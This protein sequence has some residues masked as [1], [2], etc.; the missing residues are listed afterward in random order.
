[1]SRPLVSLAQ[2]PVGSGGVRFGGTTSGEANRVRFGISKRLTVIT[3]IAVILTLVPLFA[4]QVMDQQQS[5]LDAEAR[6][7]TA[8][9]RLI[10]AGLSGGLRWGKK[11]IVET[12]FQTFGIA[13]ISGFTAI[14]GIDKFG[15]ILIQEAHES[16]HSA[17]LERMRT[18]LEDTIKDSQER[19]TILDDS[20]VWITPS[21][22]EVSK[23]GKTERQTVGA[24]AI[25][26]N[27]TAVADQVRA[28][29]WNGGGIAAASIMILVGGLV[30]LLTHIVA[31]PLIAMSQAMAR[32]AGRDYDITVG[33]VP[34]T[35][36][37]S[38]GSA[39]GPGYSDEIDMMAVAIT[40][41]RD[42]MIE[43]D[44]LAAE[45]EE[46]RVARARRGERIEGLTRGFETSARSVVGSLTDASATMRATA[47]VMV[48]AAETTEAEATEVAASSGQA[49]GNVMAVAMAVDDLSA[50]VSEI[51]GQVAR[52]SEIVDQ[53]M[54]RA[55]SSNQTVE[56]LNAAADRIGHVVKLINDIASQTNLLALNAT[57]EAARAGEAGKGF[58]V[59]AGE[60]KSLAG[61]TAR[62]TG[63]I[64]SQI[65]GMRRAID[66]TVASIGGI[67]Q[68]IREI[69]TV[70]R[71]IATSV[72]RQRVSTRQ[73]T[74]N[75][76]QAAAVTH[77]VSEKINHVRQ[78]A[79]QTGG[80]ARS[81]LT[82]ASS[83]ADLA[84]VLRTEVE[85]F[86]NQ[87]RRE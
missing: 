58:A 52:S 74:E 9:T 13:H 17:L 21:F 79:D 59:V 19:Q 36:A 5:L 78:Q 28:T 86:L 37:A 71:E 38:D 56:Q 44:R 8:L 69:E 33:R 11:P 39:A 42:S 81:V 77:Q 85:G 87:M 31:R 34:P 40:I 18:E 4:Y 62:A 70:I 76:K 25:A 66:D 26:W 43:S 75:I 80:G 12:Y 61:Q 63:D 48:S 64:I 3:V 16:G 54:V 45:Q 1:M 20:L 50:A 53:A 2:S 32:L 51:A 24:V 6:K 83:L 49:S 22:H 47:G 73:I 84:A 30:L 65:S 23:D 14:V 60:V 67:N 29:V 7:A 27:L 55:V 72:E 82:A 10:A 35:P 41:F 68:V 46:A 15:T 57:I